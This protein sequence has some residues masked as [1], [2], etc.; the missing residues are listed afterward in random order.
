[1]LPRRIIRRTSP[2]VFV[3][4]D[5]VRKP[6]QNPYDGPF[7]VLERGDKTFK[8]L[9][10]NLPY[11]V[12]VDRLKPC[13]ALGANTSMFSSMVPTSVPA[14]SR[15]PTSPLLTATSPVATVPVTTPP[16]DA[17]SPSSSPDDHSL[18]ALFSLDDPQDFPPLAV[19]PPTTTFS[20]RL[21]R[22]RVL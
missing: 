18:D 9:K 5:G 14:P 11:T 21:S 12:S 16:S 6:L 10:N 8:I 4:V 3:R 13:H 2:Q 19:R 22:P 17:G 7:Q 1:M 15:A 20:G